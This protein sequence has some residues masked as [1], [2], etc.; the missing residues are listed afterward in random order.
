MRVFD[1]RVLLVSGIAALIGLDLFFIGLNV[2]SMDQ[3]GERHLDPF[4]YVGGEWT[5]PEIVHYAKWT[6]LAGVLGLTWYLVRQP[7][8]G[9]W[10]LIFSGV[11]LDDALMIHE[12]TGRVLA[13]LLAPGVPS[14][15]FELAP[16]LGF[17]TV[18]LIALYALHRRPDVSASLRR[19]SVVLVGLCALYSVFA[20]GVDLAHA[21]YRQL[22][23]TDTLG[24][25][26]LLFIEEGGEMLSA[27]LILGYTLWRLQA[28]F[29]DR[30][31]LAPGPVWRSPRSDLG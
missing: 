15:Y 25:R 27:S 14:G 17:A 10:S 6:L 9:L 3:G 12:R 22:V 20:L 31:P 1:L 30:S 13:R 23:P 5:L 18:S 24:D 8:Y 16:M 4:L 29:R 7:L 19:Y 21:G 2:A 28:P 26:L 11:A